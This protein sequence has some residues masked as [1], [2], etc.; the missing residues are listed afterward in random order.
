MCR[1]IGL[2]VLVAL[3]ASM[4]ASGTYLVVVS[5]EIWQL[6]LGIF[7]LCFGVALSS[8]TALIFTV[9]SPSVP[10][11]GWTELSDVCLNG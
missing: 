4:T 8:L 11:V 3:A 9:N 6:S 5:D 7:L 1:L 10:A 2:V